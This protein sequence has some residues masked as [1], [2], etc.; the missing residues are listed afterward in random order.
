[1]SQLGPVV[2]VLLV[3]SE[4][5]KILDRLVSGTEMSGSSEIGLAK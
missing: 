3:S 1:V 5:L 4:V 2:V